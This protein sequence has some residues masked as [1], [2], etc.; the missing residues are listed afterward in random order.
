L[1]STALLRALI[2]AVTFFALGTGI[3]IL[4]SSFIP[5]LLAGGGGRE[6]TADIFT[7]E[8]PG[9]R[10]N[11]TVGNTSGAALPDTGVDE[12]GNISDLI[13]GKIKPA[14]M[15]SAMPFE[16]DMDQMRPSGYTGGGGGS[17]PAGGLADVFSSSDSGSGGF[18]P[19]FSAFT[20]GGFADTG[21]F[22]GSSPSPSNGKA[23]GKDADSGVFGDFGGFTGGLAEDDS[24]EGP[25]GGLAEDGKASASASLG[26]FTGKASGSDDIF[27]DDDIFS[28][29]SI[30]SSGGTFGSDSPPAEDDTPERKI[31][32]NKAQEFEGDFNPKEIASGI[33]TV[34]DR[35]KKG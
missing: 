35:D 25:A 29:A 24:A 7:S 1:F 21:D 10:V 2:F 17:G 31:S 8:A 27:D 28:S 32:G 26:G 11:I 33:R 12:V 20:G 19:D 16:K 14:A 18:S 23:D 13:S 9:S 34:L 6:D 3:W 4:I 5:E 30:Y 22:S 15:P